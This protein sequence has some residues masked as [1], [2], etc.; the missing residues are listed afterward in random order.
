MRRADRLLRLIQA[1]RRHCRPVTAQRLAEELEVS[2]RTIYR[3]IVDLQASRVPIDGE[4]GIGYI[5]RPG[6][7]LPPMMFNVEETEAIALGLR[8]VLDRGD[9]GLAKAAA[10]VMTKIS[11]VVPSTL[12]TAIR[13][14]ALLVPQRSHEAA[15]FGPNLP[16]L[17]LAIRNKTKL[18]IEYTDQ[19][20]CTSRRTVWP[21]GLVY[22]THVTLLGAWCELRGD[23][24]MFRSDRIRSLARTR[25]TFNDRNG[26]LLE[27]FLDRE[28]RV[29]VRQA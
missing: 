9:A 6:Y 1:L 23:H 2:K 17:R 28:G 20:G 13:A 29:M 7:D 8:L 5:L 12:A 21:L 24:R 16:E 18:D 19:S 11:T 25:S 26:S 10:E 27:E 14:S 15:D 3:D 22:Y 4:V